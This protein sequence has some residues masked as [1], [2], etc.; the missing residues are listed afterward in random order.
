MSKRNEKKG[1]NYLAII[2]KLIS[3]FHWK[4][5]AQSDFGNGHVFYFI[6]SLVKNDQFVQKIVAQMMWGK[7]DSG[8]NWFSGNF[9]VGHKWCGWNISEVEIAVGKNDRNFGVV[10]FFHEVIRAEKCSN[11][12]RSGRSCYVPNLEPFRF[13]FISSISFSTSVVVLLYAHVAKDSTLVHYK[14]QN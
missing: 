4:R 2:S 8:Q 7:N 10:I 14:W 5:D 12:L 1:L 13:L 9:D 3:L 11:I 6:L